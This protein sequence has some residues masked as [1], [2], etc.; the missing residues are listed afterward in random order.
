MKR[1]DFLK[2]ITIATGLLTTSKTWA[3]PAKKPNIIYI[4][5]DDAGI[6]DFGCYGGKIIS[7]PN[8][9]RLAKEGIKFMQHYS[10]S[11]VCAPSRSCLMTGQH[12]GHTTVRGNKKIPLT[13]QDV[14]IAQ[15]LKNA[16]YTTGCIGKWGLGENESTGQ[17]NKKGFD[18]FYGFL[19]QGKAHR[20][21]PEYL[22]RN[23]EKEMFPD[24]P[25]KRDHYAHDL[26]TKEALGFIKNFKDEPFFLYLPYT[27]PHVDLD[28]PED[29]MMPY[30]KLFGKEKP[31]KGNNYRP[32]PTPR[33]CF[34]GM[35]SRLDRDVG[36]IMKLLKKLNLHNDTL[37]LF[38]SDNGATSAG[39]ADPQFFRGNGP[40][41]GIKRDLYEGGII[42]P[43]IARW[44]GKIKANTSTGHL[45]AF[46]DV[47]P[48]VAELVNQQ[49]PEP[50]D[51]ISFLPTLLGK[52]SKQKQHDY[53]YWEFFEKGGRQALRKGDWKVVRYNV[54]KKPEG[55]LE[56]YNLKADPG[57]KN[58]IASKYPKIVQELEQ[59]LK[60]ARTDSQHFK[61]G[62]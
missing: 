42:A 45:S 31:F 39:G 49:P 34:A 58:N 28:V 11:T 4:L 60:T 14:T 15:V 12:T 8:V 26:F 22:W 51:G 24:N 13:P 46:W 35:V 21:Y 29:S 33:A 27:I 1:R 5:A 50:I 48:T 40:Y 61:F 7:T 30:Y 59:L 32:H 38:S 16:G 17:P 18:F 6:A 47:L 55:L 41:R 57:E 25:T 56:L 3:K 20:Y 52:S 53:L 43:M 44:P 62:V 10:G 9:D 37:V 19:N 2:N 54:H 23:G 36:A